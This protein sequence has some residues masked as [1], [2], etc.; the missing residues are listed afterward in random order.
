MLAEVE[1]SI[2]R[3]LEGIKEWTSAKELGLCWMKD[4]SVVVK[5]ASS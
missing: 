5:E 1:A 3:E 2:K 4:L